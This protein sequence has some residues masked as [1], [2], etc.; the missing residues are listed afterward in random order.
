VINRASGVYSE[1]RYNNSTC[2]R[3]ASELFG[4][5]PRTAG[6]HVGHWTLQ[7]DS[8]DRFRPEREAERG[9]SRGGDSGRKCFHGN[10]YA[11]IPAAAYA[12]GT[13]T[14]TVTAAHAVQAVRQQYVNILIGLER[15]LQQLLN[16]FCRQYS[17]S[18]PNFCAPNYR[19]HILSGSGV[20]ARSFFFARINSLLPA[21]GRAVP[22]SIDQRRYGSHR[23]WPPA[24]WRC[25]RRTSKRS[26]VYSACVAY[27]SR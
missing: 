22:S 11:S 10:R 12:G 9:T 16:A 21:T 15:L 2:P 18:K 20:R 4:Q 13:S 17:V 27:H 24:A 26:C 19:C 23:P 8:F 1:L 5:A 25:S 3:H 6:Q 7:R 14:S